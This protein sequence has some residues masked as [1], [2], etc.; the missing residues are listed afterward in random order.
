MLKPKQLR[1][2]LT[3]SVPLL[4][5]NPDSLNVF[6]DSGRIASTL[7]SSLSFEYQ[8][9]LNLVITDYAD[10]IDL[11]MVP[12]LAWLRENQPDIMA[13]E[14]KRRTGFTF[15][16]DVLSDTL[17][18]ISIDLQL[19]ERVLVKQDGD[20]LHVDHI[21]EPPLPENVNRPLQLYV[22][23]ELVSELTP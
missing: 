20:A 17:C 9:Q 19:T 22:H 16:V 11:V 4:A 2:A 6:I 5:R 12:V 21:G 7:A 13:T 8:Y 15:K 10:D 3:N 23:G 14:E 1:E 18:D